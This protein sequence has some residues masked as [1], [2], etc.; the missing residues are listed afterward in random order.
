MATINVPG[1]EAMWVEKH[2]VIGLSLFDSEMPEGNRADLLE[3]YG[4]L[5]SFRQHDYGSA[6]FPTATQSMVLPLHLFPKLLGE[7]S[8]RIAARAFVA[9]RIEAGGTV[10]GASGSRVLAAKALSFNEFPVGP[11]GVLRHLD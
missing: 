3:T 5:V 10:W 2:G 11:N 8:V 7:N 6:A 9:A 4:E 1:A